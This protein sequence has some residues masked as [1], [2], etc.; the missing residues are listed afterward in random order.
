MLFS[1]LII[2]FSLTDILLSLCIIAPML[3]AVVIFGMS[4]FHDGE[5][6]YIRARLHAA[7]FYWILGR[8]KLCPV[9]IHH[10]VFLI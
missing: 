6:C 2:N 3:F 10:F 4:H 7:S 5:E 8:S 9:K 1:V